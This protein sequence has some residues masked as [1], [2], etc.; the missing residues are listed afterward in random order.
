LLDGQRQLDGPQFPLNRGQRRARG[1][2]TAGTPTSTVTRTGHGDAPGDSGAAGPGR[3]QARGGHTGRVASVVEVGFG[4]GEGGLGLQSGQP[5][6]GKVQPRQ[7][8]PRLDLVA[9]GDR[10]QGDGA[11]DPE[12]RLDL[13]LTGD[14]PG[15][16][17][18]LGDRARGHHGG[19]VAGASR[20]DGEDRDHRHQR[21]RQQSDPGPQDAAQAGR[22][23]HHSLRRASIGA[24]RAARVA[25]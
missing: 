20:G 7:D 18:G 11:G 13:G 14:T 19:H 17:E 10:H 21:H 24:S 16:A 4:L 15:G 3:R 5:Q 23:A 8:L 2:P 25:G 9:D 6:R 1:T 22:P 12:P